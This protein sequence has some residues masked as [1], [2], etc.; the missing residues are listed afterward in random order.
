MFAKNINIMKA[1]KISENL[2]EFL[3]RLDS[4]FD[5][6]P[7]MLILLDP[8]RQKTKQNLDEFMA[9]KLVKVDAAAE[10]EAYS[11]KVEDLSVFKKLIDNLSTLNIAPKIVSE[12]LFVSLVS[13][14][15][16]FLAKLL[17]TIYLLIPNIIE[18]SDRGLTLSQLTELGKY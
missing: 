9:C 2:K 13:Q 8:E 17:R 15:D 3:L 10:E 1:Q 7:M 6:L 12:S 14:Y 11:L 16:A 5:T 18:S 4:S